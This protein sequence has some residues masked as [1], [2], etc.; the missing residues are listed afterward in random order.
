MMED[1]KTGYDFADRFVKSYDMTNTQVGKEI[2][3]VF[4]VLQKLREHNKIEMKRQQYYIDGVRIGNHL[5]EAAEVA[6][7]NPE[8][9]ELIIKAYE[10]VVK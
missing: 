6:I 5:K 1:P 2:M 10:D 7:K 4:S 8:L 9:K 3:D